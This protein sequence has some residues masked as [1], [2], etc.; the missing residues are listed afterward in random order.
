M[1]DGTAAVVSDRPGRVD[2]DFAPPSAIEA[3]AAE[4]ERAITTTEAAVD[5]RKTRRAELAQQLA[6][7]N[8]ESDQLEASLPALRTALDGLRP[9]LPPSTGGLVELPA[10]VIDEGSNGVRVLMADLVE[11]LNENGAAAVLHH[12]TWHGQ[13]CGNDHDP[14]DARQDDPAPP[15][16]FP[17]APAAATPGS[18]AAPRDPGRLD[19]LEL[20]IRN[21]ATF[22]EAVERWRTNTGCTPKAAE[23]AVYKAKRRLGLE[24]GCGDAPKPPPV[25]IDTASLAAAFEARKQHPTVKAEPAPKPAKVKPLAPRPASKMSAD[26]PDDRD[27]FAEAWTECAGN[28]DA[29]AVALGISTLDVMTFRNRCRREG[30]I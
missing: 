11:A 15:A 5:G 10:P 22:S 26:D 25:P 2:H 8:A 30:T 23:M 9:L 28:I 6:A 18:G 12:A 1:G 14:A 3:A 21:S 16:D 20:I 7:L 17:S 13:P 29:T 24:Y 27:V 19:K 4:I